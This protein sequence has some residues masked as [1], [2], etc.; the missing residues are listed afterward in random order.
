MNAIGLV[1]HVGNPTDSNND[2]VRTAGKTFDPMGVVHISTITQKQIMNAIGLVC[3][4]GNPTDSNNDNVRNG[5]K[6]FDPMGVVHIAEI[7][8]RSRINPFWIGG[9]K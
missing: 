2:N 4:V 5:G 7:N 9:V 3:H 1:C 6:T 8:Q